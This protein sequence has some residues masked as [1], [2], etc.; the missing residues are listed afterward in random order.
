MATQAEI[1]FYAP[2]IGMLATAACARDS[3]S[4]ISTAAIEASRL[5]YKGHVKAFAERLWHEP[6]DDGVEDESQDK[7]NDPPVTD[8]PSNGEEESDVD[9]S[10]EAKSDPDEGHGDGAKSQQP[11][12]VTPPLEHWR[13]HAGSSRQRSSAQP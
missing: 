13:N 5:V 12:A 6:V 9:L 2:F 8:A 7:Q 10:N 3:N 11:N 4:S 1:D